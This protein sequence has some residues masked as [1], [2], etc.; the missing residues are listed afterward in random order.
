MD[1]NKPLVLDQRIPEYN[2]FQATSQITSTYSS[3]TP[4]T[5]QSEM[6]RVSY[7]NWVCRF[8]RYFGSSKLFVC[9]SSFSV[10]VLVVSVN[11]KCMYELQQYRTE[12]LSSNMSVVGGTISIWLCS[13]V[14][15][16]SFLIYAI[17]SG[18]YRFY[19]YRYDLSSC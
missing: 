3:I 5:V 4:G 11:N 13:V 8:C 7:L 6:S 16:V 9:N 10:S 12:I 14:Q 15:Y 1:L 17:P 18:K 19:I 2:S